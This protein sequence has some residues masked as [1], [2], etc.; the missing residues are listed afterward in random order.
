MDTNDKILS[1]ERRVKVLEEVLA[2]LLDN[3]EIKI[4]DNTDM[5]ETI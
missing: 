3:G 2:F 5:N 4:A 1:L